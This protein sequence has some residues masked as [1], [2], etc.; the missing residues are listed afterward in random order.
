MFWY[1]TKLRV[2]FSDIRAHRFKH[3]FNC[4]SPV[5]KCKLGDETN[6]HFL[7][8]CSRFSDQRRDLLAKVNDLIPN[9]N[10]F[11]DEEITKFLLYGDKSFKRDINPTIATA[12]ISYILTTKRFNKLEAF[13]DD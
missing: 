12:T 8:H 3:K 4:P 11:P 10:T 9:I 7:L 13:S 2:D 1:F 6:F 5:C